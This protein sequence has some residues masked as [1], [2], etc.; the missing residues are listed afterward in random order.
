VQLTGKNSSQ[1][2]LC[3][4]SD[5]IIQQSDCF[6]VTLIRKRTPINPV[7]EGFVLSIQVFVFHLHQ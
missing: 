1:L 4:C 2:C 6:C 3:L 7:K 5:K